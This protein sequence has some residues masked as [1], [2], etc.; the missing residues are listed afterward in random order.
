MEIK[1]GRKRSGIKRQLKEKIEEWIDTIEDPKIKKLCEQDTI[2]TGGSIASMLMGDIVNDYDVYFRTKSTAAAV[3]RYYV[4][5][6]NEKFLITK[7]IDY[8][9]EVRTDTMKNVLGQEEERVYIWMQSAGVAREDQDEYN[10]FEDMEE[11]A[12]TDFVKDQLSMQKEDEKE[13]GKKEPYRPVFIS[14]NAIT[15]SNDMQI[16]IRFFGEPD[17]IHRNY[18]FEHACC[19]Y[20]YRDNNLHTTTE[21]LEAM[22]SRTLIYRGSLYPIASIFRM[23]K[24]LERGWRI[25]AGQQ[26][27]I[28]WQISEI[29]M[30]DL[31]T[32]REQLTGVDMAY[33]YELIEALSTVKDTSKIDS[34]YVSAIIDKIFE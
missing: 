6:F 30:K 9:P 3:A 14:Q 15:L 34:A 18:D 20:D 32:L 16:I 5:K 11:N 24:F 31:D 33:M 23:K 22:M 21:A 26:L 25:T 12:A 19:Y 29:D 27:K 28:M 7:G 13:N 4:K 2:V 1:Y 8:K 10:Y 17:E